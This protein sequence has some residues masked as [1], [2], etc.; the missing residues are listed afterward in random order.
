MSLK[1]LGHF[2]EKVKDLNKLSAN[3]LNPQNNNFKGFVESFA[4][5][6]LDSNAIYDKII[7]NGGTK[8]LAE[9]VLQY[10]GRSDKVAHIDPQDVEKT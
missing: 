6:A 10:I 3:E 4:G 5:S 1:D 2:V 7:K 8:E 9:S